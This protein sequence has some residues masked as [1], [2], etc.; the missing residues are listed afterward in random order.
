MK[1]NIYTVVVEDSNGIRTTETFDDN[2]KQALAYLKGRHSIMK[3][4]FNGWKEEVGINYYIWRNE[5]EFTKLYLEIVEAD[6]DEDN[7]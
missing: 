6:V 5:K 4:M 7:D 2:Q 1:K 3:A